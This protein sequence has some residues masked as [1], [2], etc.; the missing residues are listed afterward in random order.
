MMAMLAL[1][2]GA[3]AHA[4]NF[5]T[6]SQNMIDSAAN[7]PGLISGG[8]YLLGLVLGVLGI[9]KLKAHVESPMQ[10]HLKDAVVRFL[11]GGALFAL[12]IAYEAMLNTISGGALID[13]ITGT[14]V[15]SQGDIKAAGT[16]GVSAGSINTILQN[17]GLSLQN[18]PGLF[19]AGAY[20]LALV[21]GVSG[22]LQL[23]D[24]VVNPDSVPLRSGIIKLIVAGSLF[25]LTTIIS[26]V[27]YTISAGDGAGDLL[28]NL[29]A[30][31]NLGHESTTEST[32]E[33]SV[34]AVIRNL[35]TNTTAFPP[36][37]AAMAYL[38]G[39]VLVIW[40]I[41]KIKDHIMNPQQTSIWEG[42]SRLIAGGA[43]F[44]LPYV[45][46]AV[47]ES[48]ATGVDNHSN[49]GSGAITGATGAGLDKMLADFMNSIYE[50]SDLIIE[51]FG[52]VAGVILVMIGITRLMKSAQEG[53]RGPGGIG[54]MMTF[55]AGGALLSFSP[56]IASFSLSLF[57][58][59]QTVLVPQLQYKAGLGDP[60]V[61]H[62]EAVISAI[63][64]FVLLLGLVSFLRGI[65]IV[66]SVAEGNHQ[67]SMMAGV[68]HLVGGAL[69][70]NLGPFINAVESTLGLSTYGVA[71]H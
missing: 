40:G 19:S 22:I 20:L 70:V 12:P 50:P 13:G 35:F 65:F 60:E 61:A 7:L 63:I 14:I 17:I 5:S 52:Y 69:A 47:M 31:T 10:N 48:L 62:I 9:L 25:G 28:K 38:F 24:H 16:I 26:A 3:P 71:F 30:N 64:E 43:M 1:A 27:W 53:P 32:T 36:F 21:F 41:L 4:A 23:K 66:R 54:T 51:F 45:I 44:G 18:T 11:A 68:T 15:G 56:M 49:T 39:I 6:V 29:A 8:S 55:V 46:E 57:N 58:Q 37:L 33:G 42:V 67:A 2:I 34:G 59:S